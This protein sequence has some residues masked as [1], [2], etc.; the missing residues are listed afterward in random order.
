MWV[1]IIVLGIINII[2]AFGFYKLNQKLK[3]GLFIKRKGDVIVIV[4]A[5]GNVIN[6]KL[7]I[8]K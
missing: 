4:D 8:K 2:V 5:D 7:I 1:A 6:E 3:D